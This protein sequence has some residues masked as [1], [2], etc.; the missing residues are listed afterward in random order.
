MPPNTRLTTA[1]PRRFFT[2]W[3]YDPKPMIW[4]GRYVSIQPVPVAKSAVAKPTARPDRPADA[5]SDCDSDGGT[6]SEP[7]R[8]CRE[9]GGGADGVR[10]PDRGRGP[11][12]AVAG[13]GSGSRSAAGWCRGLLA[14][15]PRRP[16]W[17]VWIAVVVL[18]LLGAL[19][20]GLRRRPTAA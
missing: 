3:K 20:V 4:D 16:Q 2:P 10:R 6:E 11:A 12:R 9:A 19:V 8:R 7:V 13:R 14:W 18:A 15:I 1:Q 17:W 5:E